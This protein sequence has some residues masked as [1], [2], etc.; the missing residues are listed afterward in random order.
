LIQY[1]TWSPYVGR[2]ALLL[3]LALLIIGC[4][5]AYLGTKL[6]HPVG[7]NRPGK[8]VSILLVVMWGLSLAT[9]AIAVGTYMRALYQQYGDVTLPTNPI[10]PITSLSG[11]AT[12]V[13]LVFLTRHHGFKI[14]LGTA[15]VG[16][17]AAPMIFELP[18]DLIVMWR[19]YPPMPATQFTLLYFL[20]LFLLEI[21]TFSL[22]TLSPLT[23]VSKYTL[24]SL[25]AMFF[26]FAIWALLGFSYP[27][28]PIPIALNAVSKI[29]SFVV[30]ITLFLP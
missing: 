16:I 6:H 7:V 2:D 1:G 21:S 17:M 30:V 27:S 3:A 24:F 29:L 19:T 13:V 22:L 15:I 10:S 8:T 12:F 5:L 26:V 23:R 4:V 11:L 9:L 18:F 28:S 25:A 20:P 14:A